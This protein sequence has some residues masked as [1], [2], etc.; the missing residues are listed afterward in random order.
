MD[1][2]LTIFKED[3]FLAFLL[4]DPYNVLL[5]EMRCRT[6]HFLVAPHGKFE[7]VVAVSSALIRLVMH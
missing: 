5:M 7:C 4:N 6:T 2:S 1:Q 3:N